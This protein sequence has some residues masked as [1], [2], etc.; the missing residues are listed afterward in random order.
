ME[1]M[2]FINSKILIILIRIISIFNTYYS[3][4]INGIKDT[5]ITNIN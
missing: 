1:L 4:E 2:V 5:N 3:L